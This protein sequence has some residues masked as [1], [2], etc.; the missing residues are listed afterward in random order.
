MKQTTRFQL[1]LAVAFFFSSLAWAR[2]EADQPLPTGSDKKTV[3]VSRDLFELESSYVFES[4]LHRNG[5]FGDQYSIQNS[6]SYAHRF[7]LTGQLYLR[8]GIAY[9]RFD[10]GTTGA[11]VPDQLQSVAMMLGVDYMHNDDIGAFI[12]LRPGFYTQSDFDDAAFDV[13][14]TLGRVFVLQPDRL[15]FF[16]GANAAF[17]RGRWPVIPLAGLIWMPNDQWKVVAMLPEPR[18]IYKT[19]DRLCF[20]AGGELAGGS[21]RTDRNAAIVPAKLNGAQVD[22]AEYR[23]GGGLIYCPTDNVS[24]NLGGGYVIERQFDFHRADIKYKADGAPYLRAEIK[25]KF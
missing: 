9:E 11:P 23:V 19:S 17:L 6:F 7:F 20:W 8:A 21:F 4:D 3:A 2:G 22:Y 16:A 12:Q 18:V 1:P 24:V 15:Y 14:I 13:P 10:F 25:T 5:S